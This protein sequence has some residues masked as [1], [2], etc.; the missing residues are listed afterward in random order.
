[1]SRNVTCRNFQKGVCR[2]GSRCRFSHRAATAV[3]AIPPSTEKRTFYSLGYNYSNLTAI[4]KYWFADHCPEWKQPISDIIIDCCTDPVAK[5]PDPFT[6]KYFKKSQLE[7][8][9]GCSTTGRDKFKFTHD[10]WKLLTCSDCYATNP[11]FYVKTIDSIPWVIQQC[12]KCLNTKCSNL[13]TG[14]FSHCLNT[15]RPPDSKPL[16]NWT[17]KTL[18]PTSDRTCHTCFDFYYRGFQNVKDLRDVTIVDPQEFRAMFCSA[19]T[20]EISENQITKDIKGTF[21]RLGSIFYELPPNY[22]S[23]PEKEA[24]GLGRTFGEISNPIAT[25]FGIWRSFYEID[26]NY[27]KLKVYLRLYFRDHRLPAMDP[28]HKIIIGYCSHPPSLVIKKPFSCQNYRRP[29][30]INSPT[31]AEHLICPQ[32]FECSATKE[33]FLTETVNSIHWGIALCGACLRSGGY[34]VHRHDSKMPPE[35][36]PTSRSIDDQ[37]Y[38]EMD[39]SSAELRPLHDCH[40]CFLIYYCGLQNIAEFAL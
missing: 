17:S 10:T 31:S 38:S 18:Q 24:K 19:E 2:Y 12:T 40:I 26:N 7:L 3:A 1:M 9:K 39:W 22:C 5:Y 16:M 8:C 6:S 28:M 32:C 37:Y 15:E 14:Y 33:F 30:Q 11:A 20:T 35:F 34:I 23:T 25:D 27:N 36:V 29:I 13:H 21:Y 4:V